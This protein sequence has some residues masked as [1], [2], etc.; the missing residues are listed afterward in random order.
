MT[1]RVGN[2]NAIDSSANYSWNLARSAG[3]SATSGNGYGDTMWYCDFGFGTTVSSYPVSA[4]FD[5]FDYTNT[6]KAK[7]VRGIYGGDTNGAIGGVY[8][9]I[10]LFAGSWNKSGLPAINTLSFSSYN[11]NNIAAGSIFSL[12]G[13]R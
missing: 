7:T 13:I 6:N 1:F 9:S 11:S 8:G 12:Y 4:V 10:N 2:S 3:A 5:I